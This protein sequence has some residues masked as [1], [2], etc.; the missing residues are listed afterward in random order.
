MTLHLTPAVEQRL[1]HL[2]AEVHRTPDE[3]AEEAIDGYLKHIEVLTAEVREG[4]DS[5]ERDGWL[6]HEEVFH[7]LRNRL[8]KS[9]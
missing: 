5:A 1:E 6:T 4:H 2:A 7:R 8:Q 3:L 9:A